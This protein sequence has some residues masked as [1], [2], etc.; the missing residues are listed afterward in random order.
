MSTSPSTS[1][2]A[3]STLFV[4]APTLDISSL[5]TSAQAPA[6]ADAWPEGAGGSGS[7]DDAGVDG[8]G[9]GLSWMLGE[10]G[11]EVS[12][13]HATRTTATTRATPPGRTMG[14]GPHFYRTPAALSAYVRARSRAPDK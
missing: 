7:A 11:G 13:P 4:Q 10:V 5:V 9:E 6:K 8:S 1:R 12:P 2:S 14:S 3:S